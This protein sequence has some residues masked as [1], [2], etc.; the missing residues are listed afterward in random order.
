MRRLGVGENL[1]S[2]S[3]YYNLD[4]N[5]R[6][7]AVNR[8]RKSAPRAIPL[9]L[10]RAKSSQAEAASDKQHFTGVL[11]GKYTPKEIQVKMDRLLRSLSS[12]RPNSQVWVIHYLLLCDHAA[13]LPGITRTA[14]PTDFKTIF[15]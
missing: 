5:M 3:I 6:S 14:T 11:E 12:D 9:Y 7:N 8:G 2:I 15:G 4:F 10:D 1:Y 13:V